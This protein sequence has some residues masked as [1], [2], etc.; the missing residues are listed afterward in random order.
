MRTDPELEF[1]PGTELGLN[2]P[3]R[4]F[5]DGVSQSGRER[6][7]LF[8][9]LAGEA[10]RD[11]SGVSGLDHPADGRSFARLDF[12][13]DGREDLA[14]VNANAPLFQLFRNEVPGAERAGILALRFVGANHSAGPAPGKSSRSGIGARVEVEVGG[15]R[16]LREH[17][18]GDGFAAWNGDILRIGLGDASQAD[19]VR[20]HWPSGRTTEA[21]AVEAGSLLVVHED[22]AHGPGGQAVARS[23]Y[24]APDATALAVAD[25][26]AH[27]APGRGPLLLPRHRR[28]AP[29][30]VL[31]TMA[32]WCEVCLGELPHLA[33]LREKLGSEV[34]LVGVP[35]DETDTPAKLRA[36][37]ERHQPPYEL[38]VD[39]DPE[40]RRSVARWLVEALHQEALPS[41]V[42]TDAEGRV[43]ETLTGVPTLSDLRRLRER[44]ATSG[45]AR[46]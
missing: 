38:L 7:H 34:A 5:Q 11:V 40:E 25:P 22:P 20:V 1:E 33:W 23:P 35:M 43:L 12:D 21:S 14:V 37:V 9:N 13:R 36:Y 41:S 32:T 45:L 26:A 17:R 46:R 30:R 24:S 42:V 18:G 16:L 4:F 27:P 19:R 28:D 15:R 31:T 8:L 10:F 39:L 3:G 2:L 44:V 6:N 29:L